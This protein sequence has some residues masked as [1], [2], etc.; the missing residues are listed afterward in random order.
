M[1]SQIAI[2]D[3][4]KPNEIKNN[5][6]VLNEE[7]LSLM[8]ETYN[9]F[10][11]VIYSTEELNNFKDNILSLLKERD[12]I[13][14]NKLS[15]YKNN[16]EKIKSDF[17][18]QNKISN[19]KFSKIIETQALM[20][21]RLDQLSDYENFVTKTNDKLVSHEVRLTNIRN[22]FS[23]ATQ[24]YDKIYLDNLELPGYIGR[25]AKYKNCQVFFLDVIKDLAK[26][27]IYRE[28]NIIDLKMYKDKL[29]T[30]I[31]SM[32]SILDNNNESQIKYINEMKEK[33]LK[34]CESMFETVSGS[35][36]DIRVE[37]SKYAVNLISTSMDL[38]KKWEKLEKIKEELLEKFNYDVN[39]YQMLT[40]DT[41][42]SFEEFKTEYGVIRRKFMELAEFIK[43]VRFRKNIGGNVKKKEVKQ[44]VKKMLKKRKSF[45]GEKVQLLSDITSI[46]NI[47][48][49]KYYNIENNEDNEINNENNN[50]EN[51]RSKSLKQKN[52]KNSNI[53]LKEK[54]KFIERNKNK[55]KN[56]NS[57][58]KDLKQKKEMNQSVEEALVNRININKINHPE[59]EKESDKSKNKSSRSV[60]M[61]INISSSLIN[62]NNKK[63]KI[64]E[65]NINIINP[66][67]KNIKNNLIIDSKNLKE[68]DNYEQNNLV[69]KNKNKDNNI[70]KLVKN[71]SNNNIELRNIVEGQKQK[72][73]ANV[74]LSYT[75]KSKN[76]EKEKINNNINVIGINKIKNNKDFDKNNMDSKPSDIE[77]ASTI[78]EIKNSVNKDNKFSSEK[79]VS[80]MSDSNGN[81]INKFLIN[82]TN[83]EQNDK[84]IKELASE[85]EQSTAKKDKFEQKFKNACNNIEPINLLTKKNEIAENK[86]LENK[87][88]ENKEIICINK[89]SKINQ[90]ITTNKIIEHNNE[91]VLKSE[92]EKEIIN[93]VNVNIDNNDIHNN[94]YDNDNKD[95]INLNNR[96]LIQENS[97]ININNNNKIKENNN[98]SFNDINISDN[99]HNINSNINANMIKNE[100]IGNLNPIKINNEIH[101]NEVISS[102]SVNKKLHAF[103]QKLL[104]LE[105]YTKE[106]I[107][108]LISEINSLK[109][110]SI[111]IPDKN[112]L[113]SNKT[114]LIPSITP[115]SNEK[116]KTFNNSFNSNPNT[117]L[118]NHNSLNMERM[119]DKYE[120]IQTNNENNKNILNINNNQ[121]KLFNNFNQLDKKRFSLRNVNTKQA[122]RNSK[123]QKKNSISYNLNTNLS[124]N[125]KISNNSLTENN[126]NNNNILNN[127]ANNINNNVNINVN[128]SVNNSNINNINNINNNPASFNKNNNLNNII[129]QYNNSKEIIEGTGTKIIQNINNDINSKFLKDTEK[130]MD[131]NNILKVSNIDDLYNK[132]SNKSINYGQSRNNFG[133]SSFNGAEI[134][135]V[136][137]NKLVNHQLPKNRLIPIHMTENEYFDHFKSK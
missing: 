35:M 30:I 12:K 43:D 13:I 27:N 23:L 126:T 105:L 117:K 128:N 111:K 40:D 79:S 22:D 131:T 133:D 120:N 45:E 37:N 51:N 82:D 127:N 50:N 124:I 83:Q 86:E 4:N 20:T 39:K 60:N 59:K 17:I 84:I 125:K 103:D 87:Q 129:K 54:E 19:T 18:S 136:D 114:V 11:S 73:K 76:V 36:K 67:E 80:F 102:N 118:S 112:Y 66:D 75:N 92:K 24:K 69:N 8:K 63:N 7:N 10:N 44:M 91:N 78:S 21:S 104:N 115:S 108:D 121:N 74:V 9:K 48:Y 97:N 113:E 16:T 89:E 5:E 88:I 6:L 107:I 62:Y 58:P 2:K 32:N 68:E 110:N 47:D 72:E 93:K 25:C 38:S 98:N 70:I 99:N 130:K 135:L 52:K 31:S 57:S 90:I 42:K 100:S 123:I 101:L 61:N 28:K 81:N 137:L 106:K 34:D 56:N 15:E 77:E 29:E 95:D 85:L 109:Q 1:S 116:Y 49:K 122:L 65:N 3:Q 71:N 96:I 132:K 14:L 119:Q 41:I 26:L 94:N 33:I 53:N 55:N 134:K 46:E 64:K